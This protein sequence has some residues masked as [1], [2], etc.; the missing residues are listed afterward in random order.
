MI[1]TIFAIAIQMT[2]TGW[3]ATLISGISFIVMFVLVSI[4]GDYK[5]VIESTLASSSKKSKNLK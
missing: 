3:A 5:G 4:K 2:P 1:T